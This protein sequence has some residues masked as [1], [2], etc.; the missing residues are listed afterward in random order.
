MSNHTILTHLPY[1]LS[2][3][4]INTSTASLPVRSLITVTSRTRRVLNL[5]VKYCDGHIPDTK[6]DPAFALPFDLEAVVS[7][8]DIMQYCDAKIFTPHLPSSW[9]EYRSLDCD[10]FDFIPSSLS[11]LPCVLGT[12]CVSGGLCLFHQYRTLQSYGSRKG[13]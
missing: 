12:G 5:C 2:S 11:L 10:H 3:E 7:Q 9:R 6:H 13:Y 8:A 4:F 1:A